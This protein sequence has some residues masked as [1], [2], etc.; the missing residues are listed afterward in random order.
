MFYRV[1][2]LFTIVECCR[3]GSG[4]DIG[5]IEA[6]FR[7]SLLINNLDLM[8]SVTQQ[9]ERYVEQERERGERLKRGYLI[10]YS[11]FHIERLT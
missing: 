3:E 7:L 10:L 1:K 4:E 2:P 5:D 8:A 9:G 11:F 6:R